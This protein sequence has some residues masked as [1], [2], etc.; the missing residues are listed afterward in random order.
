MTN[1]P[2]TKLAKILTNN[3]ISVF[4]ASIWIILSQA[5]LFLSQF[6]TGVLI[7]RAL[8]PDGRGQYT[9]L[10]LVPTMLTLVG[11]MGLG[12]ANSHY[13]AKN[14]GLSRA[15]CANN[16]WFSLF[17]CTV[18]GIILIS[19]YHNFGFGTYSEFITI[20][21]IYLIIAAAFFLFLSGYSQSLL[22]GTNHISANNAVRLVQPF[23]LIGALVVIYIST[24][25]TVWNSY[26]AWLASIGASCL[27][28][29]G[30]LIHLGL[31]S[32][33]PD[34]SLFI[35]SIKLGA[36]G[37]LAA[38]AGFII[39]QSDILMIRHFRDDAETG[40]YSIAATLAFLLISIPQSTGKV[41]FP[42]ISRLEHNEGGNGTDTT[43]IYC[44]ITFLITLFVTFVAIVLAPFMISFV[45]G[46]AY[47]DSVTPFV[48]LASAIAL[49]GYVFVLDA[50]LYAREK[51]WVA[52]ICSIL[53][54]SLNIG[55]NLYLIP[56][57]GAVGAAITSL[58]SYLF[59]AFSV[60]IIYFRLVDRNIS[61]LFPRSSDFKLIAHFVKSRILTT[62]K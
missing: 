3:S 52:T 58:I 41:L 39:I 53:A 27:I 57:Y 33:K 25:L 28:A 7:A 15:L 22:L 1:I 26:N 42:Y 20:N 51:V 36:K 61:E 8:L 62:K 32:L 5:I 12:I 37:V 24:G 40:I 49:S 16:I 47:A 54:A 59:Y 29:I 6:L 4:S 31:F 56:Q 46:E 43:I 21:H 55:L 50:Q 38:V 13:S 2:R 17:S 23:V 44:R 14:P 45:Y 19:V 9:I 11:S 10:L 60:A 48:I 18:L 35:S 30:L 34:F